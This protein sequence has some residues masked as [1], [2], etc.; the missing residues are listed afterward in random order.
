MELNWSTFLLEILNFLILVWI[1]KHFL[2]KPVLDILARRRADI[3]EKI[4]A[5]KRLNA[6]AESLKAEYENR[7]SVWDHERQ[8]ARE[9][10][11]QELNEER[12]RQLEALQTTLTQEREKAAVADARQRV[13]TEHEIEHRA[14]K[15][16]AQFAARLLSQGS[17]PELENR[18]VTLLLDGLA[19]LPADQTSALRTQWGESPEA[20]SVASAYPLSTDQRQCLE[21]ALTGVADV[22]SAVHFEQDSELLAGLRITIGSWVLN[23]NVKNDLSGFTEFAHVVS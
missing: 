13:K 11:A 23:A 1:L 9:V 17:G 6:D 12:Q 19:N 4:T 22:D 16:G 20:I 15:Q 14:L 3:E 18:L 21:R 8:K 5:A 2:Y 10:L 7:L